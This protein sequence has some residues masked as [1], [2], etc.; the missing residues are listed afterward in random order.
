MSFHANS[1]NST[2]QNEDYME[3]VILICMLFSYFFT[4]IASVTMNSIVLMAVHLE[5]TLHNANKYFV[6]CLAL[7][8]FMVAAFS[9]TIRLHQYMRPDVPLS[10]HA[11]RF[12]IWVDI[13]TELASITTLTIISVDRYFKVSK[14]LKYKTMMSTTKCK[15]IIMFL[16]LYSVVI[17]FLGLIPYGDSKGVH[18]TKIGSCINDNKA[19]YTLATFIGF[20]IPVFILI[21]M[22]SLMFRIVKKFQ[23]SRS[24][25]NQDPNLE[26]P[27]R[28]I[29]VH[30]TGK[31][32]VTNSNRR[33]VGILSLV[34]GAFIVCWGPFFILF[35]IS[36]YNIELL[37]S[38][39]KGFQILQIVCFNILPYTNSFLNPIIYA[40]F[41][42]SFNVAIKNILLRLTG[43]NA[44]SSASVATSHLLSRIGS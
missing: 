29:R 2:I 13:F 28:Q 6:A 14:P 33:T 38:N 35:M 10:I 30:A 22:C 7:S 19:F 4:I 34:V 44:R 31:N 25:R 40:Y 18:I 1:T 21:V 20:F 41:D 16:W 39:K 32:K 26:S 27:F 23:R 36:Q 43:K 42:K 24:T 3:N 8:D 12:W 17:A 5:K 37:N 15:T 9:V 11:C